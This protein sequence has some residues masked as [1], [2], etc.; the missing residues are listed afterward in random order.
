MNTICKFLLF[1]IIFVAVD[2]AKECFCGKRVDGYSL[3]AVQIDFLDYK[4]KHSFDN[5]LDT[6]VARYNSMVKF[7][8]NKKW[9]L[10]S[11]SFLGLGKSPRF[12]YNSKVTLEG[13]A[14][15][16]LHKIAHPDSEMREALKFQDVKEFKRV[17]NLGGSKFYI[18][19]HPN[20][21]HNRLNWH[22]KWTTEERFY[23]KD[24]KKRGVKQ[25]PNDAL[26][27]I[28]RRKKEAL[29]PA[30]FDIGRPLFLS[31]KKQLPLVHTYTFSHYMAKQFEFDV[32]INFAIFINKMLRRYFK[33]LTELDRLT[34]TH[35]NSI[36]DFLTDENGQC[37]DISKSY[38]IWVPQK[39]TNIP[40]DRLRAILKKTALKKLNPRNGLIGDSV[41]LYKKYLLAL[42]A[43]SKP[44]DPAL[45]FQTPKTSKTPL[46]VS[47]ALKPK[48][49]KLFPAQLLFPKNKLNQLN[50]IEE[51]PESIEEDSVSSMPKKNPPAKTNQNAPKTADFELG[52][53][54]VIQ[55]GNDPKTTALDNRN[56]PVQDFDPFSPVGKKVKNDI[57]K[58]KFGIADQPF[59]FVEDDYVRTY[60]RPRS[61]MT[62]F[63]KPSK[64]FDED[65]PEPLTTTKK[66][67]GNKI[68]GN[69]FSS[70]NFAP[71]NFEDREKI[72][73][74]LTA[75][76]DWV[77]K[78]P[79][80]VKKPGSKDTNWIPDTISEFMADDERPKLK[81]DFA[82]K[83]LQTL[84]KAMIPAMSLKPNFE[85]VTAIQPVKKE[86]PAPT[87]EEVTEDKNKPK[88][89]KINGRESTKPTEFPVEKLPFFKDNR[90]PNLPKIANDLPEGQ[91]LEDATGD[92]PMPK[93]TLK[94]PPHQIK[95]HKIANGKYIADPRALK[96]LP[97]SHLND[98]K[99]GYLKP[100]EPDNEDL[101]ELPGNVSGFLKV[102]PG[103][104]PRFKPV[105]ILK[106]VKIDN[107]KLDSFID[108]LKED[109]I[110]EPQMRP[111]IFPNKKDLNAEPLQSPTLEDSG[112]SPGD[113]SVYIPE[114]ELVKEDDPQSK[115]NSLIPV[116]AKEIF[117]NQEKTPQEGDKLKRKPSIAEI[118]SL[119]HLT[120]RKID[121][122]I[123]KENAIKII[124]RGISEMGDDVIAAIPSFSRIEFEENS[125]GDLEKPDWIQSVDSIEFEKNGSEDLEDSS[126]RDPQ[127][128][129]EEPK[130]VEQ[131]PQEVVTGE[132]TPLENSEN[133]PNLSDKSVD[134]SKVTK[135]PA[136]S[137]IP[138]K[139]NPPKLFPRNY[140]TKFPKSK[141]LKDPFINAAINLPQPPLK[142]PMFTNKSLRGRTAYDRLKR[143]T[144]EPL[145]VSGP[146]IKISAK[147]EA[148]LIQKIV[149][150]L[151][152]GHP[153][154]KVSPTEQPSDKSELELDTPEKLGSKSTS[155]KKEPWAPETT[156]KD[157]K[158][159]KKIDL[160][161][162]EARNQLFKPSELVG[163]TPIGGITVSPI[164]LSP[165][166]VPPTRTYFK[167]MDYFYK[168]SENEHE[169]YSWFKSFGGAEFETPVNEDS[170]DEQLEK[171]LVFKS[172]D[173]IGYGGI[174]QG[175]DNK[176][177]EEEIEVMFPGSGVHFKAEGG[178]LS[179]KTP[180]LSPFIMNANNPNLS[181]NVLQPMNK[182]L[183][184][185]KRKFAF[186]PEATE[187]KVEQPSK[188][189]VSDLSL[190]LSFDDNL[191]FV[192]SSKE[193]SKSSSEKIGDKSKIEPFSVSDRSNKTPQ[194]D[195]SNKSFLPEQDSLV[196]HVKDSGKLVN[197]VLLAP[198]N[199]KLSETLLSIGKGTP[200][201]SNLVFDSS[202][203]PSLKNIFTPSEVAVNP[204]LKQVDL[205]LKKIIVDANTTPLERQTVSPVYEPSDLDLNF[206]F[207]Q[208]VNNP[209]Q[210]AESFKLVARK[211]IKH[212]VE[213]V[214][215]IESF[216]DSKLSVSDFWIELNDF[217]ARAQP[218]YLPD[219]PQNMEHILGD[220]AEDKTEL[221]KTQENLRVAEEVVEDVD[222]EAQNRQ[223][224]KENK[225]LNKLLSSTD[226]AK[227]TL[228]SIVKSQNSDSE[229]NT[230]DD[231][232]GEETAS[233]SDKKIDL[234]ASWK[235]QT[236]T[237]EDILAD[238]QAIENDKLIALKPANGVRLIYDSADNDFLDLSLI[239]HKGN[240]L[241]KKIK[242]P[243]KVYKAH[244]AEFIR[245]ERFVRRLLETFDLMFESGLLA[246]NNAFLRVYSD[247][248]VVFSSVELSHEI[249]LTT[250]ITSPYRLILSR[251]SEI[252][253]KY[254][255]H[256][257]AR[258]EYQKDNKNL[259]IEIQNTD[260]LTGISEELLQEVLRM[261]VEKFKKENPSISIGRIEEVGKRLKQA[262]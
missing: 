139:D 171:S 28:F 38:N 72:I 223:A 163:E 34:G 195:V 98:D 231:S 44:E 152:K 52:T 138:P 131:G 156:M 120:P 54:L 166:N 39:V 107:G 51:E 192:Q 33:K 174:F 228:K 62:F 25:S 129:K 81:H 167:F 110:E 69:P 96:P 164:K 229:A 99:S 220:L 108:D 153:A 186:D 237:E 50:E 245:K 47:D 155:S 158:D 193:N 207:N 83:N 215:F 29:K 206:S 194:I 49:P 141:P 35:V 261:H 210:L 175:A 18:Y 253:E 238:L 173:V 180:K 119:G 191:N 224:K 3:S 19:Y 176:E 74:A 65:Q 130:I 85:K 92:M 187:S 10:P 90:K 216:H 11:L 24:I 168:N 76:S 123:K 78:H 250:L 22:T 5:V 234:P 137:E 124:Q 127:S 218:V 20:Q 23:D 256:V 157:I 214:K 221:L 239:D 262:S 55:G 258:L 257:K 241:F 144:E 41:K 196:D 151:K 37:L 125:S 160:P 126:R 100:D 159:A 2:A 87:T 30:D 230:S 46:K 128:F 149:E 246:E 242:Y 203:T 13:P 248:S 26:N 162:F 75:N 121:G 16:N 111:V 146:E 247:F 40:K 240:P 251:I 244:R 93:V 178:P 226:S 199:K 122:P 212:Y 57:T 4:R 182:E 114:V 183:V 232:E 161:R 14:K 64:E 235:L 105:I 95:L 63:E 67:S 140:E 91:P 188:F 82:K 254:M 205:K 12:V 31:E 6:L 70:K 154:F 68:E 198:R 181:R 236:Q 170:I 43:L 9:K 71:L 133:D 190:N 59:S 165:L 184:L 255:L 222:K 1:L 136:R 97:G 104:V 94:K 27:L 53:P 150:N 259:R 135:E 79:Q 112:I 60:N 211:R 103:A 115:L 117:P 102:N 58:V 145:F 179:V 204:Q 61:R 260:E 202:K 252:A 86:V 8:R 7:T 106:E 89:S 36:N 17:Y 109:K 56:A 233:E 219:N 227:E 142:M 201:H 225:L 134:K 169:T 118:L 132:Q 84:Q 48:K 209:V 21:Q 200:N 249:V 15:S 147:K 243:L 197:S 217:D 45:K 208:Q 32:C 189:Q 42:K 80:Q 77:A 88:Y 73:A 66:K 113:V 143:P 116:I 177:I 185:N 148:K 213:N 101:N 172:E